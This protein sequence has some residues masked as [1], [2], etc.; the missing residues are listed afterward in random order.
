MAILGLGL[1]TLGLML[2]RHGPVPDRASSPASGTPRVIAAGRSARRS[3]P[4]RRSPSSPGGRSAPSF[5]AV[6]VFLA[7]LALSMPFDVLL[8]VG[9]AAAIIWWVKVGADARAQGARRRGGPH[10]LHQLSRHLD[11]HDQHLLRLWPRPVRRGRPRRP[12]AVRARHVGADP[13]VVQALARPLPLRPA[14]M[15]VAHAVADASCSRCGKPRSARIPGS[16]PCARTPP[17]AARVFSG[18]VA[19]SNS[20]PS[21]RTSG[22]ARPRRAPVR[23]ESDGSRCTMRATFSIRSATSASGSAPNWRDSPFS[24]CAGMT[25]ATVS[26][27]CIACSIFATLFSPSSR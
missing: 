10:G 2:H 3:S 24:V 14:R 12:V 6:R 13:A 7:F 22:E 4:C 27:S 1:E 20:R 16:P 21:G 8:A 26:C 5:D 15:A 25:K 11:R 9:W 18:L 17:G 23:R 19:L